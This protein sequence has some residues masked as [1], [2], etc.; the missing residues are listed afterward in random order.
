[1]SSSNPSTKVLVEPAANSCSCTGP[2]E[3]SM[4]MEKQKTTRTKIDPLTTVVDYDLLRL[5]NDLM[6]LKQNLAYWREV[7]VPRRPLGRVRFEAARQLATFL[8]PA[9]GYV[10]AALAFGWLPALWGLPAYLLLGVLLDRQ[11]TS[12]IARQLAKEKDLDRGRYA[13][14]QILCECLGL[15]PEEVNIKR[16][17]KMYK[18]FQVV[19]YR[20]QEAAEQQMEADAA[21]QAKADQEAAAARRV[22]GAGHRRWRDAR[23][24]GRD[25]ASTPITPVTTLPQL[26]PHSGLP[27]IEGT[28]IDVH[29][30]VYGTNN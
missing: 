26:N 17:L 1:M 22:Q 30:N 18:D 4:K 29:G 9:L 15:S 14:T 19:E 8:L 2:V 23:D 13:A 3:E 10:G 12:A 7:P 5:A 27:M 25:D 6:E 16:V 28:V 11:L 24:T 21:A 20:R